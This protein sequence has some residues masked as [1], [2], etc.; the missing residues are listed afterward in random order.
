MEGALRSLS[1]RGMTGVCLLSLLAACSSGPVMP[2][3]KADDEIILIETG[4]SGDQSTGGAEPAPTV[5]DVAED[6]EPSVTDPVDD[7]TA[8][9]DPLNGE[10]TRDNIPSRP[11]P[12]LSVDRAAGSGGR[13]NFGTPDSQ[14]ELLPLGP[15][16]IDFVQSQFT[17]AIARLSAPR[18]LTV[19][20]PGR[21]KLEVR[22]D[23]ADLQPIT[24][25]TTTIETTTQEISVTNRVYA[26]LSSSGP[27][28]LRLGESVRQGPKA[29]GSEGVEFSWS[30]TAIMAGEYAITVRLFSVIDGIEHDHQSYEEIVIVEAAHVPKPTLGEQVTGY[31]Q[32][33]GK[34]LWDN[35][36]YPVILVIVGAIVSL[37]SERVRNY[38]KRLFG[39]P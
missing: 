32:I 30:V 4:W 25:E 39:A 31:L 18:K 9:D 16:T 37:A 27:E 22:F 3:K 14:P 38:I 29:V 8:T 17:P 19:N 20:A 1:I 5:R 11:A 33:A 2:D 36:I 6:E 15:E 12:Y 28:D 10:E 21:V 7:S 23:P 34:W 26:E 13:R 24:D 35:L